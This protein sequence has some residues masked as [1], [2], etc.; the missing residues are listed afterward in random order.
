M[1]LVGF[2]GRADPTERVGEFVIDLKFGSK[3]TLPIRNVVDIEPFSAAVTSQNAAVKNL[4]R[5]QLN[6]SGRPT[7]RLYTI[8]WSNPTPEDPIEFIDF[9]AT[10]PTAVP[11]CVAMTRE[12]DS[13]DR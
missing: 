3:S 10:H 7:G 12:A 5:R 6:V 1:F 13:R 4:V 8:A 11:F 9:K 2:V